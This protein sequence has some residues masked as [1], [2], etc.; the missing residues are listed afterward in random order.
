MY[1]YDTLRELTR[2][3]GEQLRRDASAHRLARQAHARR[4]RRRQR[5]AFGAAFELF[6]GARRHATRLRTDA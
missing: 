2:E 3:H 5:L 1:G 6:H 4:H